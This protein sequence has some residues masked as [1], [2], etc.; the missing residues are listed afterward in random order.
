VNAEHTQNRSRVVD[1]RACGI[2]RHAK[3]ETILK[4]TVNYRFWHSIPLIS[5]A[6]SGSPWLK[7]PLSVV[8]NGRYRYAWASGPLY[9]TEICSDWCL[10]LDRLF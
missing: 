3:I 6:S 8:L 9:I 7:Y 10:D 4:E 1:E 5:A 2:P